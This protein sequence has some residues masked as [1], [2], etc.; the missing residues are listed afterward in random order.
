MLI[1]DMEKQIVDGQNTGD[2]IILTYFSSKKSIRKVE[3][4]PTTIGSFCV[5]PH[6]AAT[7]HPAPELNKPKYE[8]FTFEF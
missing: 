6:I 8:N 1:D 3:G 2:F 5:V 7:M 4:F